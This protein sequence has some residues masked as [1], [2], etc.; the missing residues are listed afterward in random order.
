[1]H[2]K[3]PLV[4]LF[5]TLV[6]T[7]SLLRAKRDEQGNG[8][9]DWH[10]IRIR[11]LL[12]VGNKGQRILAVVQLQSLRVDLNNNEPARMGRGTSTRSQGACIEM[13]V[14]RGEHTRAF[15]ILVV[16]TVSLSSSSNIN[17]VCFLLFFLLVLYAAACHLWGL[18]STPS[19]LF[20]PALLQ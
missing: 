8:Q 10:D 19:A 16:K 2:G 17:C 11:G 4:V 12:S 7:E 3:K 5:T 15:Q 9:H 6:N 13:S 18:H 14:M 1:M 20:P